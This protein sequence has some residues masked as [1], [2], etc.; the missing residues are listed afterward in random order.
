MTRSPT[1]SEKYAASPLYGHT[2]R[3]ADGTSSAPTSSRGRY[4]RGGAPVSNTST[5]LPLLATSLPSSAITCTRR[6]VRRVSTRWYGSRRRSTG[7]SSSYQASARSQYSEANGASQ[8]ASGFGTRYAQTAF[9]RTSSPTR[10][11]QYDASP[12]NGQC[13]VW[14]VGASSSRSKS[15]SGTYSRGG[16]LLSWSRCP[17]TVSSTVRPPISARMRRGWAWNQ[18]RCFGPTIE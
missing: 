9:S 17:W 4:A 1:R 8:A 10:T 6:L 2:L 15:S 16:M 12:L 18:I 3:L 14:S 5:A 11:L 7:S 13:V